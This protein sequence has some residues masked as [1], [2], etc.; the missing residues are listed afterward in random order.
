MASPFEQRVADAVAHHEAG[1]LDQAEAAYRDALGLAPGHPAI[2][3]NLGVIAAANGRHR[4]AIAQF[5]AAIAVEP[6]Y[7]SAHYNRASALQALG[8]TRDALQSLARVS[9]V[10]FDHQCSAD[11]PGRGLNGRR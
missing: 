2:T 8:Q 11:G 3:H 5:D 1:R 9:G 10:P 7:A 6:Q 4:E